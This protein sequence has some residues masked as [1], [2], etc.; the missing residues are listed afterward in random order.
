MSH[1]PVAIPD[2]QGPSTVEPE[3]SGSTRRGKN[4]RFLGLTPFSD[5]FEAG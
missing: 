2:S 5:V 3:I 4:V 1:V